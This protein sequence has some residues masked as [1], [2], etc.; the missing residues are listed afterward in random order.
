MAALR[1][2]APAV[3]ALILALSACAGARSAP[4]ASTPPAVSTPSR[5]LALRF[6]F[7]GDVAGHN[8]CRDAKRGLPIFAVMRAQ[9]PDF[10]LATG[11]MIYADKQ[12]LP[13]GAYGN[14]QIPG[15]P[16]AR[17]LAGYRAHWRY[18]RAD[19]AYR[20]LRAAVPVHAIWDD[21]E[22][23]DDF[24]PHDDQPRDLDAVDGADGGAADLSLMPMG[25]QAFFAFN[26][27]ARVPGTATRMYRRLRFGVRA[28][29][30][31]LDT[32][33]YRDRNDAADSLAA[34][35]TMLGAAQ[36]QWLVQGLTD[37]RARWKF[38]VSSVPLSIPTGDGDRRRDG[39]A[40]GSGT[41][42]FE[43]ELVG[44]LRQLAVAQVQNLVWLTGDVHF[45]F[46]LE[47]R[48]FPVRHPDFRFWELGAGPL[49][50]ELDRNFT[51]DPTLTPRWR[52]RFAVDPQR[53]PKTLPAALSYFN[54]GL[55]TLQPQGSLQ[56]EIINAR[57]RRVRHLRLQPA[58]S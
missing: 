40:N 29:I 14:R 32:R 23:V 18:V 21:H 8:V 20:R 22:V 42:G 9:H 54:F 6:A 26:P 11:D 1:L 19:P 56:V 48:P 39:W 25:R 43:R 53:P 41:T 34:P 4:A 58:A 17:T 30:F 31:L 55:V 57:G 12:C 38:V 36:R 37:S 52:Y 15:P 44:M 13:Q 7:G 3:L 24:G 28:D 10:F 16:P 2:P 47:S 45:A 27:K 49:H 33:Q 51:L 46:A 50:A 35:K 5:P